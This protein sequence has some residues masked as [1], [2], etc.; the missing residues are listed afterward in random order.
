MDKI[1][2]LGKNY[3]EH[4]HEL[5]EALPE[6]PVVF[7]KPP[8]VLRVATQGDEEPL[9]LL[10]PPG[11]AELHHEVEIVLR[12]DKGGHR[13]D[14]K[15][16]ER[17][18]GAVSLGLDMTQRDKQRQLKKEGHPWTIS[19]VFPDCAVVGPWLRVS[20]FPEY[21]NEKFTLA[22]DGSVRQEGFGTQMEMS[23]AECVAYV[24][25]FFPLHAGDLIFTGTPKGVGPVVAGNRAMLNWGPIRYSVVWKNTELPANSSKV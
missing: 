22:V 23:P 18:I 7:I 2:C 1:V 25:E 17:L 12:L 19:K 6:K 9:S 15:E 8:S 24:S 21:L 10:V 11:C 16:A 3:R 4:A 13:L 20:E 14:V 5:G